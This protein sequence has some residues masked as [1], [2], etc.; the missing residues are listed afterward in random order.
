MFRGLPSGIPTIPCSN[1]HPKADCT[2][3]AIK[4]KNIRLFLHK[5]REKNLCYFI[6][7]EIQGTFS[8]LLERKNF[9]WTK[10]TYFRH[11]IFAKFTISSVKSF[12][13]IL[14]ISERSKN[15]THCDESSE[16][17]EVVDWSKA[18]DD[19]PKL[20]FHIEKMSNIKKTIEKTANKVQTK[21]RTRKAS[22]ETATNFKSS[23]FILISL[24]GNF[25]YKKSY[26]IRSIYKINYLYYAFRIV[27]MK[28]FTWYLS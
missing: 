17:D 12:R 26:K 21:L 16:L 14:Q 24:F 28:S 6:F 7:W 18:T 27:D 8:Y 13:G 1:S 22:P 23:I 3:I 11:K 5:K 10:C 2:K 19:S 4:N 15:V 25:S 9:E 20:I